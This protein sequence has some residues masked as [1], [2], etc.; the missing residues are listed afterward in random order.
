MIIDWQRIDSFAD[1]DSPED[2]EWLKGMIQDLI[3]DNDE[4]MGHIQALIQN[5]KQ[6]ELRALLHQIK[7]VCANF[8]IVKMQAA[9][10]EGEKFIKEANL[11]AGLNFAKEL[12]SLWNEAKKELSQKYS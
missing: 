1:P 9:A 10:A 8:G 6:E 5:P 11:D 3:T 2:Q 12:P 7:G 4:K